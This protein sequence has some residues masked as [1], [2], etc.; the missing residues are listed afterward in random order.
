MKTKVINSLFSII[1][2]IL[3]VVMLG[4]IIYLLVENTRLEFVLHSTEN[5]LEQKDNDIDEVNKKL[6]IIE[7]DLVIWQN[8]AHDYS[9]QLEQAGIYVSEY[10]GSEDE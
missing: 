1:P 8:T 4:S 7:N 2:A 10:V 5:R 3:V 9:W 6:R